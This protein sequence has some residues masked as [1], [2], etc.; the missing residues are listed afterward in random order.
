MKLYI[1]DGHTPVLCHDIEKWGMWMMLDRAQVGE[2]T[3]GEMWVSTVF[4]GIDHGFMHIGPPV[5]F[6]TMVFLGHESISCDRYCTWEEAEAG[7][8]KVVQTARDQV[9]SAELAGVDALAN[10]MTRIK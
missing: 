7:H 2:T 1:L 10:L 8:A 3:V 4:L 9:V 6:E 5:L